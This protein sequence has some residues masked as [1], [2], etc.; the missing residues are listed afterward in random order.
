MYARIARSIGDK[1][2]FRPVARNLLPVADRALVKLGLR[3]TPWPTLNLTTMGRSSGQ[4]RTTP[5]Y[6]VE[7]GDHLVV[8]ATNYGR[9]E[10]DWSRNLRHDPTCTV[11]LRRRSSPAT[12]R[13]AGREQS[14]ELF[15][16][17][18]EFYPPYQQYRERA[19]RDIPIWLLT[20]E[21]GTD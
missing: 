5:L 16:R 19:D 4:A 6:F 2:W 11:L 14:A 15:A 1:P 20:R 10:P 21:A 9:Q 7:D 13:L 3:A 12:A 8:V 17:F 18:V